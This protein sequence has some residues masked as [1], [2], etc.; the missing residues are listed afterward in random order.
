MN[1][2]FGKK[3]LWT[4]TALWAASAVSAA[5]FEPDPFGREP[6]K[7]NLMPNW[8]QATTLPLSWTP[9]RSR[10][11]GVEKETDDIYFSADEMIDN[12]DM[13]TITAVG[14]VNIYP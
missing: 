8:N 13:Q 4:A 1:K 10:P 9:N 2:V 11:P 6:D 14:D 5:A 12:K 7:A 3:I